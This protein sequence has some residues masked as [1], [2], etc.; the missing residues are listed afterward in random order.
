M[1][2]HG[3]KRYSIAIQNFRK[4]RSSYHFRK[5]QITIPIPVEKPNDSL[6]KVLSTAKKTIGKI[7]LKTVKLIPIREG[8]LSLKLQDP[9]ITLAK[10]TEKHL[11]RL[12]DETIT[13]FFIEQKKEKQELKMKRIKTNLY[14]YKKEARINLKL[15]LKKS[16]EYYR[17]RH[18]E[19]N[20]LNYELEEKRHK[21]DFVKSRL[22]P[23]INVKHHIKRKTYGARVTRGKKK[24]KCLSITVDNNKSQRGSQRI[25]SSSFNQ[26]T[27]SKRLKISSNKNY[28]FKSS[29]ISNIVKNKINLSPLVNKGARKVDFNRQKDFIE[30]EAKKVTAI[31]HMLTRI[32]KEKKER[33]TQRNERQRRRLEK[34]VTETRRATEKRSMEIKRNKEAKVEA[35]K[36]RLKQLEI[37]KENRKKANKKPVYIFNSIV[38]CEKGNEL[39]NKESL[40]ESPNVS[41]A[42]RIGPLKSVDRNRTGRSKDTPTSKSFFQSKRTNQNLSIR[43]NVNRKKTFS[44][45]NRL[46][47][48]KGFN[49]KENEKSIGF[50]CKKKKSVNHISRS[51]LKEKVKETEEEDLYEYNQ[52]CHTDEQRETLLKPWNN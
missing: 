16:D 51:I 45:Y 49:L 6:S 2:Q 30:H 46:Q 40:R 48:S 20:D 29:A 5:S 38:E 39:K 50:F 22:N 36:K 33:I 37:L 25:N 14:A 12:K 15:L 10:Q 27:N 31:K 19:N 23:N 34:S 44:N 21:S 43:Q 47:N 35:I 1:G 4:S 32:N 28:F 24:F 9:K 26:K 41:K 42:Y 11:I 3:N 17:F 18:V 7:L 52:E 13:D 8:K